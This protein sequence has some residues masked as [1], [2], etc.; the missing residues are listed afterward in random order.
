MYTK[1]I[2]HIH[3]LRRL[4]RKKHSNF[5]F[6]Q[7]LP[8]DSNIFNDNLYTGL[9]REIILTLNMKLR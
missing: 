6:C 9:I 5:L 8:I 3:N 2:D 4:S 7:S 1:I